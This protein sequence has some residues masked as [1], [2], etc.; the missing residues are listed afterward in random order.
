MKRNVIIIFIFC[1][2]ILNIH[3]QIV[4]DIDGNVYNTVTIGNQVWMKENLKSNHFRNGELIPS[5]FP[6]QNYCSSSVTYYYDDQAGYSDVYG[7]LYNW[8]AAVDS[9]KL[10]PNGWHVPSHNDWIELLHTICTSSTCENDFPTDTT[11]FG[12]KG[13]N[14]GGMLK[15][16]GNVYWYNNSGATNTSG[17]SALPGGQFVSSSNHF[18]DLGY[19]G[20]FLTSTEI[21]SHNIW[22]RILICSNPNIYVSKSFEKCNFYS[23]RCIRDFPAEVNSNINTESEIDIFPNPFYNYLMISGQSTNH[24]EVIN[25]NGKIVKQIEHCDALTTINLKELSAGIYLIKVQSSVGLFIKK[26]VKH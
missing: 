11:T 6:S 8:Y 1:F 5:T 26:I 16:T 21:N 9:R 20:C 13:T 12:F 18:F 10:C 15:D 17:F 24:I 25:F 19:Y 2:W 22:G 7:A 14:E 3:S 4:V 23:V